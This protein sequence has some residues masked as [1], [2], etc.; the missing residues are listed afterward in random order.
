MGL[1]QTTARRPDPRSTR[2]VVLDRATRGVGVATAAYA[3]TTLV[4]PRVLSD[5][6]AL[7]SSTGVAV[8][9][10]TVGDRDTTS[11]L[12]LALTPRGPAQRLA[13][14]V[15]AASDAGDAVVFGLSSLPS[16]AR[17]KAVGVAALWSAVN[18]ALLLAR[19]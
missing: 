19:R 3:I 9:V 12:A 1:L 15:R 16:A 13:L 11:G 5:P 2:D 10:R 18:V 17:K 6:T 7:G 8:L 14:P 4:R